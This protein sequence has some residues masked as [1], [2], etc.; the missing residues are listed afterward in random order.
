M[1]KRRVGIDYVGY[2]FLAPFILYLLVWKIFPMGYLGTLSFFKWDL[3]S[4]PEFVSLQNYIRLFHSPK[5]WAAFSHTFIY[6]GAVL[7]ISIICALFLAIIFKEIDVKGRVVFLTAVFVPYIVSESAGGFMWVWILEE[8]GLLNFYLTKLGF[9]PVHWLTSPRWAMVSII[10]MSSWRLTGYNAII[11]FIGLQAIPKMYY[12]AAAMDGAT[13]LKSFWY[14]TL[15]LLRFMM[16]YILVMAMIVVSQ[17]FTPIYVLTGG[18]PYGSTD[19]LLLRI[20]NMAFKN[21]QMGY[22]S[23]ISVTLALMLVIIMYL[24]FKYLKPKA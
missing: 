4:S 23:A 19:V 9:S 17:A 20:Y 12:E 21:Y 11:F 15:P 5:Y 10:M 22:A 13:R 1:F 24:Q 3:I 16:L 8:G 7:G 14:I 2:L 18:G 6:I